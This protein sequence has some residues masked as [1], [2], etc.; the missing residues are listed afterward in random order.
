MVIERDGTRVRA[1]LLIWIVDHILSL[2][3]LGNEAK[4]YSGQENKQDENWYDAKRMK[5]EK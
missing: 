5:Y 4:I 2:N 1:C 3:S